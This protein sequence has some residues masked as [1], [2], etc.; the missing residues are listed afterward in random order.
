M[1]FLVNF[2]RFWYDFI[3]GDDWTVAVG[4]VAAL[5]VTAVLVRMAVPAWWLMPIAVTLLLVGSLWREVRA[6]R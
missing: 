1:Q 2:A 6:H 5:V 4:V 3:V